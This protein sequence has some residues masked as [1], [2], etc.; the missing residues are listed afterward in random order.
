MILFFS[1]TDLGFAG[2]TIS[3]GKGKWLLQG[4]IMPGPFNYVLRVQLL[5]IASQFAMGCGMTDHSFMIIKG[6]IKWVTGK[7]VREM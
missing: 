4:D 7:W 3:T 5:H 2:L 6:E 1:S